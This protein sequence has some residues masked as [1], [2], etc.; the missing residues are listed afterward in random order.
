MGD[1]VGESRSV[2]AELAY[3]AHHRDAMVDRRAIGLKIVVA[4]VGFDL[5]VMKLAIDAADNVTNHQELAWIVRLIAVGA[6]VV[7]AGMLTQLEIRSRRDR[8]VYWACQ[9]RAE[10]IREGRDPANVTPAAETPL[11][12]VRNSWASTWPLLGVFGLT[13]AICWLAGLLA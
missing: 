5:V 1:T 2:E 8:M 4:V 3:A 7:L 10:A 11:K 6:F 13:V 12:T 9:L